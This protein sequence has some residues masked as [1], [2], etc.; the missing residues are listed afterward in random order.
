MLPTIFLLVNIIAGPAQAGWQ[1][2]Y[3]DPWPLDPKMH[4]PHN[5]GGGVFAT[6]A[7]CERAG[8]KLV[9]ALN[10]STGFKPDANSH[11]QP[12]D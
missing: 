11:C 9:K 2:E 5:H 3:T 10:H 7:E 12:A 8:E 4:G 1:L 6:R